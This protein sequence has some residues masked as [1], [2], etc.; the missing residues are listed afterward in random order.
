MAQHF[1]AGVVIVV[2]HPD[3][4]QVLAFER[5]DSAD[6]WQLPQGGLE[7]GEE[8]IE[9]AWRELQEETGLTEADVVAR[10]EY[11]DWIAYEWPA[12]VMRIHGRDGKRRGQVQKWFLFDALHAD[13]EPT[14]D[15]SEFVAWRWV[16][17]DWLIDH[18]VEMRRAAY[19]RV[20]RTL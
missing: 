16:E 11:P 7:N 20:L 2:R 19:A 8:P 10:A 18:V 5:S 9:G 15:G 17:P 3:R 13:I 12:E 1:R 6:D 4:R 14:P